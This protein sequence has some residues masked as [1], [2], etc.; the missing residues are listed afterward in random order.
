[1]KTVGQILKAKREKIGLTLDQVSK[2]TKI[3]KTYLEAIEFDRYQKLPGATYAKGFIKNYALV[4][5]IGYETLVALFRRDFAEDYQGQIVPRG[6]KKSLDQSKFMWT[7]QM[8][9]MVGVIGFFLII[10]GFLGFQY[11]RS[12]HPYLV[13]NQPEDNQI[14]ATDQVK[15]SG[16]AD[17]TAV[18]KVNNQLVR[19]DTNGTFETVLTLDSGEQI[20]RVI[21]ETERG[22]TVR[23]RKIQV[24]LI[25]ENLK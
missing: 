21:A 6:L 18:V 3:R 5:G 8:T 9:T 7:P 13:V 12:I 17:S 2:I 23:E 22:R 19:V 16:T 10:G 4:L 24:K 11:Y 14:E 20:I 15:V 25:G 1:M